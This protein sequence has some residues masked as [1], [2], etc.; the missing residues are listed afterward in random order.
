MDSQSHS[1]RHVRTLFVSDVH[2][3]YRYANAAAFYRLLDQFEADYVYLVGDFIDGWRLKRTWHWQPVYNHILRRLMEMS[4][5]GTQVCYAPGNHDDFLRQFLHDFGFIHVADEFVHETADDR[6]YLI[7]HGDQFDDIESHAP[8]LSLLGTIAYDGLMCVN[9]VWN[10]VR[11]QAGLAPHWYAASVKWQVKHAVQ[12]ISRF[13]QRLSEHASRMDCDGVVCGHIHTPTIQQWSDVVY[14]NAG[15]WVEN[16]TALIED[17]SGSLHLIRAN[18]AS[19]GQYLP[20]QIRGEALLQHG[21]RG[22]RLRDT[23]S[24]AGRTVTV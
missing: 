9:G 22:T 2:L 15:D 11:K 6:R 12:F 1:R 23:R 18:L 4:V 5:R 10:W 3:G 17:H 8:W 19:P 13:E 14:C 7:L 24:L 21:G 16:C 20:E